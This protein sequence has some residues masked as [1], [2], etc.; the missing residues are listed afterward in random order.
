MTYVDLFDSI[1]RRLSPKLET[2]EDGE[3]LALNLAGMFMEVV[4]YNNDTRGEV[5]DKG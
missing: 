5:S 3:L 4:Q 2:F 1:I